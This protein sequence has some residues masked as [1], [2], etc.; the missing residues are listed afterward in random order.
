MLFS[1]QFYQIYDHDPL[2]LMALWLWHQTLLHFFSVDCNGV[3]AKMYLCQCE[4]KWPLAI[5]LLIH[6]VVIMLF[7]QM[8]G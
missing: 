1:L 4:F 6:V 7:F 5:V 3:M 8:H 2:V